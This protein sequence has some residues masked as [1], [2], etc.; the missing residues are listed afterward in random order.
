MLHEHL[1]VYLKR[2][3]TGESLSKLHYSEFMFLIFWIILRKSS[4]SQKV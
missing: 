3:G 4:N 2:Y 1:D